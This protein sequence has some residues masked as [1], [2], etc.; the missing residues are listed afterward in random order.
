MLTNPYGT[1]T[2]TAVVHLS[3]SHAR[4]AIH[5]IHLQ[6]LWTLCKPLVVLL[7][8]P[9]TSLWGNPHA[10][11]DVH[12]AHWRCELRWCQCIH[13][14]TTASVRLGTKAKQ[15][16]VESAALKHFVLVLDRTMVADFRGERARAEWT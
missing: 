15:E 2:F 6:F 14:T 7:E 1:R 8:G 5:F 13:C 4:G 11:P 12:S 9:R 3:P 16:E 10:P